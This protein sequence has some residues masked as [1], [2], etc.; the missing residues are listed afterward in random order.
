[1]TERNRPLLHTVSQVAEYLRTLLESD[2]NLRNI[3]VTGELSN[4]FKSAAGHCYFT[5]KDKDSQLKAVLFSGNFGAEHVV[6]GSQVNLRGR[7]S[8]Y[9]VRGDAQFYADAVVPAGAGALAAE[10]ER[11][12]AKLEAEGLFDPSRKR[13]L[14]PFPRR[15]GVVTSAQGA[16]IHDIANTLR[17]RYPLGE[18]V[19]SAAQVQGAEAAPDIAEAIRALDGEPGID[20]IIVARGGGSLE[21]LWAFNTEEVARAVYACRTPIVS[22]VGHEPDV[23]IA[24]YVA[25]LRAPTPTAAAAAVAPHAGELAREV[26]ALAERAGQ[27]AIARVGQQRRLVESM[28]S[29]MLR[30]LPDAPTQ[31]Q[32]VDDLVERARAGIGSMVRLRRE[33][34]ASLEK[35]LAALNPASVLERGFAVVTTADGKAV[36]DAADVR[37]GDIIRA[38][39]KRGQIEAQVQ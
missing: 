10:F 33:Q 38:T 29:G 2:F 9:P 15:I 23:T 32:R 14:P 12:K 13:A 1:M 3:W 27:A 6:N 8:F 17:A 31:R 35:A 5:V 7:V 16:V 37:R 22:G 34:V 28:V 30:R 25:D 18:L 39:V 36:S 26:A 19:L 11:L 20:V 4:V 21:D 24:D